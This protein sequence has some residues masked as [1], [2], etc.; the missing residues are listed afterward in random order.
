MKNEEWIV[1][2]DEQSNLVG[3]IDREIAHNLSNLKI[4]REVMCVFYTDSSHKSFVMQHR[5]M[6]KKQLPGMWTL[7]VTGHVDF[8]DLTENDPDGYLTA[9]KREAKEEIGVEVKNLQLMGTI[10]QKLPMNIAMM[11]IVVG[12][13]DGKIKLDTEEVSEVKI[14]NKES[15]LEIS[16]KL[17]PGAKACLEYL[18]LI[19]K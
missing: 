7:S 17:T 12:E 6:L 8:E 9:A 3:K 18:G 13:Y 10:L 15:V 2:V 5:S 16:D 11:G 19:S 4:H 1:E 14:Y